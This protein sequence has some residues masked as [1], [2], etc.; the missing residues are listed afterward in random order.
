MIVIGL[1]ANLPSASGAPDATLRAAL[2]ALES[3]DVI[4][5]KISPFYRTQAWPNPADPFFVNAVAVVSTRLK[6]P[7][8]LQLLHDIEAEFGRDRATSLPNAPRTL[9][10]DLIDYDGLVQDGP[11]RLPHPGIASRAF[12]LVP[13]RDIA[14]DWRHPIL[15]LTVSRLIKNLGVAADEPKLLT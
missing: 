12:V 14:P 5:D 13:L 4:I 8:L 9:D 2:D 6:P 7:D 11:L 10:L 3:R 15:G 1:G